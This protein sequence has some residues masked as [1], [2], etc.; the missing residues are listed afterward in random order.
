[1]EKITNF[2]YAGICDE[3]EFRA[4]ILHPIYKYYHKTG[5]PS[6]EECLD[7][8][9]PEK[10]V[11]AINKNIEKRKLKQQRLKEIPDVQEAL[12]IFSDTK[13]NLN[14]TKK[15]MSQRIDALTTWGKMLDVFFTISQIQYYADASET[16]H[17]SQYG[18]TYYIG[19]FDPEFDQSNEEELKKKLYKDSTCVLLHLGMLIHEA[20]TLISYSDDIKEIWGHSYNNRREALNL[21][22]FVLG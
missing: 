5:S 14:W 18:C 8:S 15:T 2:C 10:Y 9:S 4:F 6:L 20:F 13:S 16:L 12:A 11:D 22:L 1:M 3:K 17:G 21:L 19:A 7:Y